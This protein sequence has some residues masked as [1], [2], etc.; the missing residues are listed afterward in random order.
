MIFGLFAL[1]VSL[2]VIP[3]VLIGLPGSLYSADHLS[4]VFPIVRDGTLPGFSSFFAWPGAWITYSMF[5]EALGIHDIT[6]LNFIFYSLWPGMF[7]FLIFAL[8]LKFTGTAN[9]AS[10]ATVL[11]LA[12][13]WLVQGDITDQAAGYAMFICLVLSILTISRKAGPATI[14]SVLLMAGISVTHILTAVIALL[15][16]LSMALVD[17]RLRVSAMFGIT[18]FVAW[19]FIGSWTI[20]G[21]FVRATISSLAPIGDLFRSGLVATLNYPNVV[22][23]M[24]TRLSFL[25]VGLYS[26]LSVMGVVYAWKSG[27]MR[28]SL[29][30]AVLLE[31]AIIASAVVTSTAAG[32]EILQRTFLFSLIPITES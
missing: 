31:C 21:P 18:F 24:A 17:R 20:L 14:V 23:Q 3:D 2:Y 11:F 10:A 12:G 15:S 9:R 6:L 13:N 32:T 29:K 19:N 26:L 7:S 4:L 22:H 28:V 30:L 8:A 16:M 1:F 27:R 5:I 25:D